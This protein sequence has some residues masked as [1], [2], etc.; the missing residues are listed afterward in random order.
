MQE[1]LDYSQAVSGDTKITNLSITIAAGEQVEK[2]APLVFDAATGHYKAATDATTEAHLLSSFPVDAS[3]GA[4]KHSAIKSICIDP[5]F[6]AYPAG[7][8]AKVRAGLFAG[9]PI[10]VQSPV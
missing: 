9:T 10:S 5:D 3:A 6:V 7:M 4:K 8:P 1:V 2:F